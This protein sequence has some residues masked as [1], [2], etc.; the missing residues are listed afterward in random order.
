MTDDERALVL[1][2][3]LVER[4]TEGRPWLS[5]L[6]TGGWAVECNLTQEDLGEGETPLEAVMDAKKSLRELG[7]LGPAR[8][9]T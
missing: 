4:D 5:P 7:R 6:D 9:E 8:E 1:L 3:H 2:V